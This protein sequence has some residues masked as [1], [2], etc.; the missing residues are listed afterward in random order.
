MSSFG[1]CRSTTELPPNERPD[2]GDRRTSNGVHVQSVGRRQATWWNAGAGLLDALGP[3]PLRGPP[4]AAGPGE[5]LV[6]PGAVARPAGE[7]LGSGPASKCARPP[8]NPELVPVT[9][10]EPARLRLKVGSSGH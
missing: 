5:V 6:V 2:V 10:F 4:T 9:G 7:V 8:D 1:D 3:A